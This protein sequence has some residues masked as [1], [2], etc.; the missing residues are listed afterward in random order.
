MTTLLLLWLRRRWGDQHVARAVLG[1]HK[2]GA[3]GNFSE[4]N[5]AGVEARAQRGLLIE[6]AQVANADLDVVPALQLRDDLL[7]RTIDQRELAVGPARG[8]LCF[9][10][11]RLTHG[12]RGID[13]H[14]L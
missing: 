4:R 5:A 12:A 14:R 7:E 9:A 10:G 6:Q 1:Q 8:F 3:L 13:Q 2:T 11:R